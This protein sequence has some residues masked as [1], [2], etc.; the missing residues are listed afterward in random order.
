[1][2]GAVVGRV[3]RVTAGP[4]CTSHTSQRLARGPP[5]PAALA[6]MESTEGE[7]SAGQMDCPSAINCQQ[8]TKRPKSLRLA[9]RSGEAS[10]E[11]PFIPRRPDFLAE[12]AADPFRQRL[13]SGSRSLSYRL[14]L[15]KRK[16]LFVLSRPEMLA[17]QT[18]NNNNEKR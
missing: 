9:L 1:M 6:E 12:G 7:G 14:K 15:I 10:S 17:D 16:L 5:V 2:R 18:K 13:V 4:I 11:S 3:L 8:S